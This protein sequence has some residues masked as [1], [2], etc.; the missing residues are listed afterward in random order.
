MPSDHDSSDATN[1]AI[2]AVIHGHVQ[3]IGFRYYAQSTAAS[4]GVSGWIRNNWDGTVEVYA[5]G[6]ADA[7]AR[8]ETFLHRGPAHAHITHV[9][10]R[11]P[12]FQGTYRGF[13]IEY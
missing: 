10:I 4:L 2:Q 12:A 1:A 11:R 9:E 6:P 7:L 5:E 8:F 13:H 3:G